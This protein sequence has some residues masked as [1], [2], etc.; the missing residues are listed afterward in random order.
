MDAPCATAPIDPRQFEIPAG[1]VLVPQSSP[2]RRLFWPGGAEVRGH[3]G[4]WGDEP[5]DRW[6]RLFATFLSDGVWRVDGTIGDLNALP[7]TPR[8]ATRIRRWAAWYDAASG[9]APGARPWEM[10]AP[11]RARRFNAVT[12]QLG[13]ALKAELPP[14]WTVL[15]VDVDGWC[16][17]GATDDYL[18]LAPSFSD[19]APPVT[20]SP[21][22]S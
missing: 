13:R 9:A 19:V 5:G 6:V 18:L 4:P 15:A 20:S 10:D 14:D 11:D 7:I 12:R 8:L 17:T 1:M 22:K 16:R 2:D 3:P 21:T